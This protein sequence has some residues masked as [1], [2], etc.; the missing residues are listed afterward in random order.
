MGVGVTA[1]CLQPE[2]VL[3]MVK[4]YGA[5]CSTMR[6]TTPVCSVCPTLNTFGGG[7]SS[8][9]TCIVLWPISS[10]GRQ[11]RTES[12]R[13]D[14]TQQEVVLPLQLCPA[15]S[16]QNERSNLFSAAEKEISKMLMDN[17]LNK[18]VVSAQYKAVV[19]LG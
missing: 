11:T 10:F 16:L 6:P 2:K 5:P 15:C 8:L 4:V 19:D 9:G 7:G 3:R 13:D 14:S 1:G 12:V 18:F 17:L